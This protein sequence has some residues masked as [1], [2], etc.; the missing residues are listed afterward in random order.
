MLP[1][2]RQSLQCVP[3]RAV[4]WYRSDEVAVHTVAQPAVECLDAQGP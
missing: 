2:S 4:Q 1:H 3:A